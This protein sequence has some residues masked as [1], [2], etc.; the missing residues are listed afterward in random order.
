MKTVWSLSA[1]PNTKLYLQW[2]KWSFLLSLVNYFLPDLLI[3]V[4]V[5]IPCCHT[6]LPEK[7][8]PSQDFSFTLPGNFS[9]PTLIFNFIIVIP[10][11][12]WSPYLYHC[13]LTAL[14]LPPFHVWSSFRI[15]L[16]SAFQQYNLS[17]SELPVGEI[18]SL[19]GLSPFSSP[20]SHHS[21]SSCHSSLLQQTLPHPPAIYLHMTLPVPFLWGLTSLSPAGPYSRCLRRYRSQEQDRP[22]VGYGK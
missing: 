15:L 16:Q 12:L 8:D 13:L 14:H 6:C 19:Y 22:L 10:V 11:F 17:W 9:L 18:R 21:C 7:L 3:Y 2:L 20:S 5:C 1:L 4:S